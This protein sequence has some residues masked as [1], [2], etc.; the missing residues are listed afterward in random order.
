MVTCILPALVPLIL[1]SVAASVATWKLPLK[2]KTVLVARCEI[3]SSPTALIVNEGLPNLV[4]KN[5][6][7]QEVHL[8]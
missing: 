7:Y 8:N 3:H 2:K 6:R 4:T 1:A 5:K